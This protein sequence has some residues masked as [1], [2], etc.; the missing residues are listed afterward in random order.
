MNALEKLFTS[1]AGQAIATRAGLAEHADLRRGRTWPQGPVVQAAL[2][3]SRL[4]AETLQLLELTW[5]EPV[6][7]QPARSDEDP[8]RYASPIGAPVSY[9]HLTLPTKRIV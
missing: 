3:P 2:G 1:S 4:A 6:V 8:P 5:G 9:T 7:D